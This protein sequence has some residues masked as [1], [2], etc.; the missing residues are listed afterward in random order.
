MPW[1]DHLAQALA[2]IEAAVRA[3]RRFVGLA[4]GGS[5]LS[6]TADDNSDLDLVVVSEDDAYDD[7]LRDRLRLAGQW[8]DLLAAFTGEH[9][10]EPR[11]IIALYAPLVH[12]DLK[13]VRLD[14]LEPRIEDP[15]IIWDRDGRLATG[16]AR[17]TA[18]PLTVSPQWIE[19][20]FWVWIHYATTKLDRGELF[21]VLEFLAFIR[22]QV[23]VPLECA[24]RGIEPRGVRRV[25]FFA[26]ELAEELT[27]TLATHDRASCGAAIGRCV[28]I[29][30]RLRDQLPPVRQRDRAAAAAREQLRV[31]VDAMSD[32]GDRTGGVGP[33]RSGL[34]NA[35][36]PRI[37]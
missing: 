33:H 32:G 27:G 24:R 18:T 1:P 13:F 34:K 15:M 12:V 3:D 30:R 21:E 37:I 6:G 29:Y 16:L 7:V 20:R 2:P 22:A 4:A 10:G 5:V 36:L 28:E 8:G 17:T 31:V 23:L 25:E 26:P 14:D 9:V 35:Y 19:D 11:L